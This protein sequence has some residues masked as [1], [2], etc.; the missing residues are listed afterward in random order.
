MAYALRLD[1]GLHGARI[2]RA[3]AKSTP[4]DDRLAVQVEF[5]DAGARALSA[6]T[7]AHVKEA[8]AIVV[9]E[10]VHSVPTIQ[11]AISGGRVQISM[12]G[13]DPGGR[14]AQALAAI[15]DAG[16]LPV[17]LIRAR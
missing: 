2:Q 5:D 6:L 14:K 1:Q 10:T 12:G 9:D 3:S 4:W 7:A 17:P 11:E 13:D 8:L 16:R 15:L